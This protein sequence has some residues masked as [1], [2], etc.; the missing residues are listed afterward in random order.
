MTEFFWSSR[1]P[2]LHA[3]LAAACCIFALG[4]CT[5]RGVDEAQARHQADAAGRQ[6]DAAVDRG[7]QVAAQAARKAG[8]LADVARD[9][10][11]AYFKSPEVRQDAA[12]AKQ[13][14]ENVGQDRERRSDEAAAGGK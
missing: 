8:E 7:A 11:V 5:D 10:T 14:I 6:V 1:R 12:A 13:A 4:A 9:K 2:P 3:L